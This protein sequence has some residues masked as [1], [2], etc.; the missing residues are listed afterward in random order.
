MSAATQLVRA[1]RAS[2][3]ALVLLNLAFVAQSERASASWLVP[4]V[5]CT[6]A[7][8]WLRSLT[9]WLAYRIAWNLAVVGA[10]ALLVHHVS[11]TGIDRLLEDGL[12]LAALC[13][14]HLLNNLSDEQRPDL[15]YFNSFLI[16][17]MTSFLVVDAVYCA[18][19]VAYAFALTIALQF[20]ALVRIGATDRPGLVR[21][22][23]TGGLV[24][25]AVVTAL[26]FAVFLFMP[27]DFKR[28][29][30]LGDLRIDQNGTLTRVE[31][32]DRIDTQ[33]GGKVDG[34]E[35]VVMKLRLRGGSSEAVP[36]YWRGAT[37]DHFDGRQWV[38]TRDPVAV[39]RPWRAVGERAWTSDGPS[40]EARVDVTLIGPVPTHLFAPLAATELRVENREPWRRIDV[41]DDRTFR[42]VRRLRRRYSFRYSVAIAPRSDAAI[43][44]VADDRLATHLAL[45]PDAST[46]ARALA[47]GLL[48]DVGAATQAARVE[49]LRAHLAANHP[50]V[51]PGEPG[52]APTLDAFIRGE[53]GGHCERFASA[54]LI[55]LR[56]E[57]IPSR[58]VTGY[59]IDPW[60]AGE[61]ACLVTSGAA[62]AWVEVFDRARGWTIVDPT[63]AAD[64]ATAATS[65]WLASAEAWFGGAWERVAG[66]DAERR[67]ALLGWVAGLPGRGVDAVRAHP[68]G[69]AV[70][71]ALAVVFAV[72]S[73]WIFRR[74]RRRGT[75]APV[76]AW[77]RATRR[78]GIRR[79]P[80]ETPRE[81]L[82]RARATRPDHP[83]L[84]ALVAATAAHERARYAGST[85]G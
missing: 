46:T 29:G 24:R 49:R 42:H 11:S 64:A 27:R 76:L 2:M 50:Y 82:A 3:V 19:F 77:A 78:C 8:P 80:H 32:T 35:R 17:V 26:T 70:S 20:W 38:A 43:T 44:P 5:A 73:V 65:G 7:G 36:L 66:F 6:L 69:A 85:S 34:S 10:F 68:L 84:P 21:R 51:A 28:R 53:G 1:Q 31:F 57:G 41:A 40:P 55:M 37:Q 54:L 58:L 9:R 15:L 59:R 12:L 25:G 83:R 62:H 71:I 30:L 48:G 81:L 18:L 52:A 63:P 14:V 23:V 74:R 45:P 79:H 13:Q 16:T 47:R 33:A 75:P 60:P 39:V 56:S 22:C 4:L 61:R 72:A 67:A